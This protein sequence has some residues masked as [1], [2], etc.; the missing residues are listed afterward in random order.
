MQQKLAA[1]GPR[2]LIDDYQYSVTRAEKLTGQTLELVAGP[3]GHDARQIL[4]QLLGRLNPDLGEEELGQ[5]ASIACL[6]TRARAQIKPPALVPRWPHFTSAGGPESRRFEGHTDR[7]CAIAFSPDGRH[8]A[9]GS[10]DMTLRFWD[11]ATGESTIL[12]GHTGQIQFVAFT[13]DGR[14]IVSL[15]YFDETVM[16]W[17]TAT[18][19]ASH[20]RGMR[21]ARKTSMQSPCPR[22]DVILLVVL[23]TGFDFGTPLP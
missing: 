6:L 19:K 22:M 13:P 5:G 7:V 15:A 18:G 4:P 8:L 11:I 20:S 3:L 2:P 14:T 1:F 9:S 21:Q 12:Q 10:D 17:N 23:A 16:L